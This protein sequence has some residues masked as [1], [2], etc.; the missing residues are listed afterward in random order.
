MYLNIR[1]KTND[2][3]WNRKIWNDI[4]NGIK[5]EIINGIEIPYILF[6]HESLEYE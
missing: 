2:F 4:K 5:T 3:L 6:I 1:N